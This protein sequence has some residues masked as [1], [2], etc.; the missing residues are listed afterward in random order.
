MKF[1]T[2]ELMALIELILG[3]YNIEPRTKWLIITDIALK[4][5]EIEEN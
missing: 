2:R 4:L 3:K 5:H 1:D